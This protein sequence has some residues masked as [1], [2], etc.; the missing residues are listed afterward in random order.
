MATLAC[1]SL[2]CGYIDRVVLKHVNLVLGAGEIVAVLGPNGSGKSTLLKTVA[3]SLPPLG[4]R[5]LIEGQD[6]AGL[7][8]AEAAQRVSYVPQE[9]LPPF[10]FH[11]RDI[12]T[13]GRL[14]R[15]PGLLDTA[16]DR[17]AATAAMTRTNAIDLEHRVVTELSGG[18]RQRVL[19][20]RALAQDTPLL[21]LDEPTA[22]LD[23]RHQV[24]ATR[25]LRELAA[26]GRTM[27]V[28]V[29]DLNLAGVLA[30]RAILIADGGIAAEGA[31][32]EVLESERLDEV[33][34][35]A[36]ERSSSSSGSLRVFPRF[37]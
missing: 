33:Y 22:H 36:F 12:V 4:G 31:V 8:F 24:E 28:A 13:M 32:R 1:E 3:K 20:A 30:H 5:V 19:L 25:L 17:E 2:D 6:L 16:E 14:A 35:V 34:G 15:S 10:R 37:D 7:R 18:E 29:H 11:V 23:A 21:L 9:E 27:L 26:D